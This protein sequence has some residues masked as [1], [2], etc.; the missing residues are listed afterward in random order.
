MALRFVIAGSEV[1][2]IV[3]LVAENPVAVV[4]NDG[5]IALVATEEE[6][7]E[8]ST[9]KVEASG[10]TSAED[11]IVNVLDLLHLTLMPLQQ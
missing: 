8:K 7:D 1:L 11:D 10:L 4:F 2:S 6:L 5:T 9:L 3:A